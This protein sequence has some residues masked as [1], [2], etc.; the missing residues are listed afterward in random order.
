MSQSQFNATVSIEF[1]DDSHIYRGSG[2]LL[3][4][5]KYILTVAHLFNSNPSAQSLS[6]SSS[7]GNLAG[8][9]NIY[10]HHGWD[11]TSKDYNHDIAIIELTT[12][13]TA[14]SGLSLW[15]ESDYS[16][17]LFSLAGYSGSGGLHTGTNIFDGDAALFNQAYFRN[18]IAGT[19]V[20]YDYDNGLES[21]NALGGLFGIGSASATADE[22]IANPGDSGGPLLVDGEIAALSSYAFRSE[23]YDSNDVT[24][25]SAGEVGVGTRIYPYI[26]WIE[27]TTQGNPVYQ[28]P[29]TADEVLSEVNEPFSGSVINYFLLEMAFPAAA[30]ISLHYRTQDGTATSGE[31]YQAA[32]GDIELAP[33]ERS[34]AIP[35]VIYGDT[36]LEANETFDMVITDPSGQWLNSNIELIAT[37]TIINNDILV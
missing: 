21:Q 22:V 32:E 9:G 29:T 6:I 35:V 7:G 11:S 27:A 36:S 10:I 13:V 24:D 26:P 31:D 20:I 33:G 34:V 15:Q 8:A 19:Q 14:F 18:V 4:G 17:K 23:L 30:L 12:P 28:A 37:H 16:D 5:G 1:R 3:A 2:V 25:F